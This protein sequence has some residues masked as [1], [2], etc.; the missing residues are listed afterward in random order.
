M[1][2]NIELFQKIH[3]VI[4]V[5]ERGFDMANW[6]DGARNGCGTTRC[7]AGWA[8]NLTT[9]EPLYIDGGDYHHE[10]VIELAKSLGT[11]VQDVGDGSEEADLEAL[12]GKLLGLE[13]DDRSLFYAGNERAAK[14]VELAAQG[15]EGEAIEVLHSRA[16][17]LD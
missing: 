5:E 11:H 3:D 9:G 13:P 8:I 6:E 12:G 7:V 17:F 14:F 1:A 2:L 10:S 4:S 16:A 15:L